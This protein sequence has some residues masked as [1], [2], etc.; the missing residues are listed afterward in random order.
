[1]KR[2]HTRRECAAGN[3]LIGQLCKSMCMMLDKFEPNPTLTAL[4]TLNTTLQDKLRQKE[5]HIKDLQ[6]CALKL[7]QEMADLNHKY[8]TLQHTL[9]VLRVDAVVPLDTLPPSP[10]IPVS[11]GSKSAMFWHN[12]CR[13]TEMQL[14]QIRAQLQAREKQIA[15]I[16]SQITPPAST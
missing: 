2:N 1:M 5:T 3:A 11:P 12:K 14:L 10:Q 4:Q 6:S 16:G 8:V 13:K 9:L 15:S 7:Q